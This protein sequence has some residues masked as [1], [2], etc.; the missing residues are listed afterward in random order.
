MVVSIYNP[1]K[2]FYSEFCATQRTT[3]RRGLINFSSQQDVELLKTAPGSIFSKSLNHQNAIYS[4]KTP[5]L[6]HYDQL[7]DPLLRSIAWVLVWLGM[8][9]HSI[10]LAIFSDLLNLA[11]LHLYC[12][13]VYAARL[14]MLQI[15]LLGSQW[16]AFRGRKWNPL[17]QRVDS[18]EASSHIIRILTAVVFTLVI[19]LLPTTAIYYAVFVA[20]RFMMF[21]VQGLIT[22]IIWSLNINPAYLLFLNITGA[23]AVKGDVYFASVRKDYT[24]ESSEAPLVLQLHTWPTPLSEILAL[25]HNDVFKKMPT[26]KWGYIFGSIIHANDLL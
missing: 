25:E 15:S 6:R 11:T 22:L 19:F 2:V 23:K 26:P 13:Y 21:T 24:T 7:A 17:K 1:L 4:S 9:G 10:Q 18:Y 3:A 12:F 16:R 8:A 5:V 20:L 14:H